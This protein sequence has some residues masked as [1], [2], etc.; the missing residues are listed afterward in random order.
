M[1]APDTNIDKQKRRHRPALIGMGVVLAF[2]AIISLVNVYSSAD[3]D[4][5]L[6]DDD[7]LM[8]KGTDE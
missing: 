5:Q 8:I 3:P 7:A 2:A 6:V 1:S 4:A